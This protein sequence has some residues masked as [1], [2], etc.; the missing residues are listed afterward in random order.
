[1]NLELVHGDFVEQE[2]DLGV[3]FVFKEAKEPHV[4][5][6]SIDHSMEGYLLKFVKQEGFEGNMGE[7]L[8]IPTFGRSKIKKICL[9][10]LGDR[11]NLKNDSIRRAGGLLIK[12][13]KEAKVKRVVVSSSSIITSDEERSSQMFGEGLMLASYE[14]RHHFGAGTSSHK[15]ISIEGIFLVESEKKKLKF[16][17]KGF[18]RA[19]VLS[20]ATHAVRDLVNQSPR[21]MCPMD[22]VAAAEKLVSRGNGISCKVIDHVEME[23]LRMGAALAVGRGSQ[24]APVCVHLVYRPKRKTKKKIAFIGKGV[25]F[26]SGGLSLKTAESMVSMKS[27]MAGAATVIGLFKALPYLDIRSEIHGVFIAVENMPSGT[28]YRPGDV[29]EAMNGMTIEILNTDAE[30]RVIL[31]DAVS[32]TVK[33]IKPDEMIDLATLTGAAIVALGDDCAPFMSNDRMIAKKLVKSAKRAGELFWE[34]PLISH[35]DEALQSKVADMN[36][37]GGRSA[38]AIK[39]GLFIQRFVN[40]IPWAHLDIAGPSFCEKEYRPDLPCGGTGFGVRTLAEYL[41]SKEK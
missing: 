27:D 38:G 25:T 18:D 14:F 10:G 39:G 23:R 31:A 35:Y 26:D 33:K 13:A 21:H 34:L 11:K 9:I 41:E 5:I 15:K 16:I 32:Y 40:N 29:V 2:A 12:V 7:R 20:E 17:Q 1:M 36:N 22:L 19:K 24:H 4:H 30:G 37:L 8:I 28:A 6:S 3:I